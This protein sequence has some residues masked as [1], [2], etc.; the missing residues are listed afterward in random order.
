MTKYDEWKTNYDDE[1]KTKKHSKGIRV[2]IDNFF[3]I[4]EFCSRPDVKEIL[5]RIKN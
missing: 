4:N 1:P 3:D 5:D 2:E